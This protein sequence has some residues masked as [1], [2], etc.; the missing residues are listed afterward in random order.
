MRTRCPECTTVFRVTSEQLRRKAGTVRCGHCQHVFNAFD[1]WLAEGGEAPIEHTAP[2]LGS[3]VHVPSPPVAVNEFEPTQGEAWCEPE[4]EPEAFDP[5]ATIVV[6]SD[7]HP[8][9]ELLQTG[10][11]R[12]ESAVEDA[13]EDNAGQQESFTE[14]PES[15]S[16]DAAETLVATPA[17]HFIV[18]E[19]KRSE[20]R[21][22]GKE[23]RRL[24][25][26]RWSPYH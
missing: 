10:D 8:M 23:C 3:E 9:E 2:E 5:A 17:D 4:P 16:F 14:A 24:C 1:H 22:V 20:E 26:S 21:R 25:R 18:S 15:V 12:E 19:R 7:W 13:V 11:L 6:D